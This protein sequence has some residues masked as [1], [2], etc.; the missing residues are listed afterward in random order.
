[1]ETTHGYHI[2][3]RK[4]LAEKLAADESLKAQ[5][6]ESYLRE[7]LAERQSS[8]SISRSEKIE[9]LD[10]VTFYNGYVEASEALEA[11][12]Q[13]EDQDDGQDGGEDSEDGETTPGS[14]D[15]TAE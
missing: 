4:D 9:E 10:I 5:M 6:A 3:L 11:A 15:G 1:M 12:N 14:T 7:L 13:P 2:L 8:A